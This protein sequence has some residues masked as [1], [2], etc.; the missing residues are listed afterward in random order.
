M[1]L[2][3]IPNLLTSLN[4]LTGIAGIVNVFQGDFTNTIFFVLLSGFFDFLDGFAA[5]AFGTTGEFG[6]QLD[7]LA[8]VVSFGVLPSLVLFQLLANNYNIEWI[9]YFGLLVGV[10][11]AL[12]LAKFN[13]DESQ[14]DKFSGLPTPAN[15][16]MLCTFSQL[17]DVIVEIPH[18]YIVLTVLSCF[19]LVSN[20]EMMAL[21]FS[22]FKFSENLFKYMLLL[23][24]VLLLVL[25]GIESLP[26]IIPVYILISIVS[27]LTDK[28]L[29]KPL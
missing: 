29:Q 13:I 28:L 15:A 8:D 23:S 4:L 18:I 26:W 25:L 27:S 6:K 17:P 7:S 9:P 21:K 19:L 5:R 12:R 14:S 24:I 10:F 16:I 2:K 1:I 22:T 20:I 3:N 11:S